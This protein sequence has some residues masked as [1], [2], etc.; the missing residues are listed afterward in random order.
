MARLPAVH[1]SALCTILSFVYI[2]HSLERHSLT[3]RPRLSSLLVLLLSGCICYA[4]SAL[5]KFVPGADGRFTKLPSQ[6]PD[7]PV[8]SSSDGI[9]AEFSQGTGAHL[10]GRP[11]KWSLPVLILIIVVRLEVFHRVNYQQQCSTPGIESF[12][13]LLLLGYQIF[14]TRRKWGFPASTDDDDP[15]RSVF[16]DIYD[17]FSGPRVIMFNSVLSAFIFSLGTF[18]S[19]SQG[20]RSG[21]LCFNLIDSRL[22]T[23][24]LQFIGLI[25]DAAILILIWRLLAWARTTK[26]RIRIVGTVLL[27]SAASVSFLYLGNTALNGFR[28]VNVSFGS[29]YGFDVVVDS[30]AF[31]ALLISLAFWICETSAITPVSILTFLVGIWSSCDNIFHMGDWLHLSRLNALGP[32]WIIAFGTI[33]FTY[34]YDLRSIVFVKRI[35]LAILLLALLLGATILTFLKRPDMYVRHP[36]SDFVYSAHVEHDRTSWGRVPPPNF[37]EWY[38]YAEGSAVIDDFLQIDRDL[39]PFWAA[40][41]SSLRKRADEMAATAGIASITIKDGQVTWKGAGDEGDNKDV[42]ELVKMIEKFSKHLPDMVLPINLSPTPRVLPT[43]EEANAKSRAAAI[44][45]MADVLSRRSLDETG[46]STEP[47][48]AEES[49]ASESSTTSAW[50]L[51]WASDF[52]QMQVEA[53]SPLSRTRTRPH[54]NFMEFCSACVQAHSLGQLVT[55]WQQSLDVCS[56]P[57][58]RLLHGLSLTD[59]RR[60]PIRQLVPLFGA[61]KTDE[62]KDIVIPFPRS[63]L[64]QPDIKWQFTRRYDSLVWRGSVGEHAITNQALRGSH[65]Y[66]LL[67]MANTPYPHDEVTMI[68]PIPGNEEKFGYERVKAAE[69]NGIAP[70]SLGVSSYAACLGTNCE[71]VERAYGKGED[72]TEPLE[73]RYVLLL[74]ED[75]GPPPELMRT[76][77]SNSVPFVSTIFRTWSTDRLMPWLHFVPIDPRY[78]G[79]HTTLTYFTGTENKPKVN[80]RETSM[81]GTTQD[82]EWIAQQGQKW[83]AKALGEKDMEIYVFRLLLEWG[84]LI[85]D[86][87]N[88]IGFRKDDK[89]GFQNDGWTR[90]QAA[91]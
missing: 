35:I 53:C 31:A 58:L 55:K 15:W 10:P 23:V 46:N 11:K 79:L 26:Q 74:D 80:G 91:G 9:E 38:K 84:R 28:R 48:P 60:P 76:I 86:L 22:V 1:V 33:L 34:L 54:W 52:R 4:V 49:P 50:E 25:L 75:D 88:E 43:W 72:V 16:D 67:H 57:D 83:A 70:F 30:F 7:A 81:P 44:S 64:E 59:P 2:S 65:K 47:I 12:L 39:D 63:R 45:S 62:F 71:V 77:R 27:L 56:Q 37:G 36:L 13:C 68:L 20:R 29:L 73:Y 89:G 8:L 90:Q 42:T 19:V 3:E 5:A 18:F 24:T 82:A 21:Y 6:D 85:N 51:T 78:Q 17:W 40:S 69:A 87:R 66:R 61:S 14:V 32:L 41:P